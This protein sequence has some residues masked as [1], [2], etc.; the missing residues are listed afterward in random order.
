MRLLM[1]KHQ[2]A[3]NC[4]RQAKGLEAQ[5]FFQVRQEVNSLH[6]TR[7]QVLRPCLCWCPK[8]LKES[9]H[10]F[11]RL[12]ESKLCLYPTSLALARSHYPIGQILCCSQAGDYVTHM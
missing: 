7:V 4:A 3:H 11:S 10:P 12:A 5:R 9:N 6:S 1:E 2:S 8:G